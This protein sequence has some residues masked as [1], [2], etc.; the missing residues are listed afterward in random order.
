MVVRK[1]EEEEVL[2]NRLITSESERASI[3]I[4]LKSVS[5]HSIRAFLCSRSRSVPSLRSYFKLNQ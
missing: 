5:A 4:D 1:Q 3:V 2:I